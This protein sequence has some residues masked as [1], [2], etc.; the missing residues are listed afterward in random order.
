MAADAVQF[1]V[2]GL[3]SA[4]T[5]GGARLSAQGGV[6]RTVRRLLE[7]QLRP[8][9]SYVGPVGTGGTDSGE[10]SHSERQ[11]EP[12]GLRHHGER[13]SLPRRLAAAAA[14]SRTSAVTGRARRPRPCAP[15]LHA[16]RRAPRPRYRSAGATRNGPRRRR[17]SAA[18]LVAALS[19][20]PSTNRWCER[21][22]L[23]AVPSV[24]TSSSGGT[25]SSST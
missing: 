22:G 9:L 17:G 7:P 14:Y 24:A 8:A 23:P 11:T 1:A 15:L 19:G 25:S 2:L 20:T 16:V 4:R 6:R 13:A 5:G 3:I 18:R 12:T 21:L 10:R